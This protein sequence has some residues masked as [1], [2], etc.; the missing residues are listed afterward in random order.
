[1]SSEIRI[2]G[3]MDAQGFLS[4]PSQGLPLPLPAFGRHWSLS[5]RSLTV[6]GS[7]KR[8]CREWGDSVSIYFHLNFS[9]FCCSEEVKL[10]TFFVY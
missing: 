6:I 3:A 10:R 2:W 5:T 1:V 9:H 8:Q 4:S 7:S